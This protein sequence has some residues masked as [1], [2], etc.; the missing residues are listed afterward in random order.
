MKLS[1]IN[2]A[3]GYVLSDGKTGGLQP[4]AVVSLIASG[5]VYRPD[6]SGVVSSD[7]LSTFDFYGSPGQLRRLAATL[8]EYADGAEEYGRSVVR[9]VLAAD[10]D[11][12][13]TAGGA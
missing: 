1:I 10:A 11:D 2:T 7:E 5:P 9:R 13:R 3:A 4:L 6:A 8:N 12:S